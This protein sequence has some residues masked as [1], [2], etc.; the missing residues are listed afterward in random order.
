MKTYLYRQHFPWGRA[1]AYTDGRGHFGFVQ[2]VRV[3]GDR[4]V[5]KY[6]TPQRMARWLEHNWRPQ[7]TRFCA[8]DDYSRIL[9]ELRAMRAL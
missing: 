5:P 9:A 3:R 7:E 2:R 4:W 6:Y 1:D 8:T